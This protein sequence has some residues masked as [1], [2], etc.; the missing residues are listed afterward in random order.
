LIQ[1]KRREQSDASSGGATVKRLLLR[2]GEKALPD[3]YN[4]N[5]RCNYHLD[6]RCDAT[7][8]KLVEDV[9]RLLDNLAATPT[10]YF[11]STDVET[12]TRHWI[13][14]YASLISGSA[15]ACAALIVHDLGRE[16]EALLRQS[17]EYYVRAHYLADHAQDALSE[18]LSEPVRRRALMEQMGLTND[19]PYQDAL[20]DEQR[21][22]SKRPLLSKFRLPPIEQ[23]IGSAG[24]DRDLIYG[25]MYRLPSLLMHGTVLGMRLIFD[26]DDE[27]KVIKVEM[28]SHA[29]N[30]NEI[31]ASCCN[32]LLTFC[33]L[34]NRVFVLKRESDLIS[35]TDRLNGAVSAVRARNTS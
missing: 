13:M 24:K 21:A 35:L 26:R 7:L 25:T 31:L 12:A 23:M 27:A 14:Y 15:E 33:G 18:V 2:H 16:A 8:L 34:F 30:P 17:F 6:F 4:Q 1:T 3:Q 5:I 9:N 20:N 10:E 28:G 19:Q 29:D 32:V 22:L 11:A